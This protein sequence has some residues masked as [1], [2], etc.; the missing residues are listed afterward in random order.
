MKYCKWVY[1]YNWVVWV[2]LCWY[3]CTCYINCIF[4]KVK[5]VILFLRAWSRWPPTLSGLAA[6]FHPGWTWILVICQH[7]TWSFFYSDNKVTGC[8][9]VFLCACLSVCVS[10][11]KDLPNRWTMGITANSKHKEID[12]RLDLK[13]IIK[14]SWWNII[15]II[16]SAKNLLLHIF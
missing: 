2:G 12:S 11:P 16:S 4:L 13:L 14:P 1:F 8:V 15:T 5:T 3:A 9:F 6:S 10:V 7:L